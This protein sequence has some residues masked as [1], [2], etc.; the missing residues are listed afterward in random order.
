MVNRLL[1]MA[2]LRRYH[3][4]GVGGVVVV[5][6]KIHDAY[7][8]NKAQGVVIVWEREIQRQGGRW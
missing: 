3:S 4:L 5:P 7:R 6:W 1:L 8:T 2:A